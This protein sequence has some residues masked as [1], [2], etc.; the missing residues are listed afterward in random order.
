MHIS[1][2]L[3]KSSQEKHKKTFVTKRKVVPMRTL[4]GWA[5]LNVTDNLLYD[6][7]NCTE[8]IGSI[9]ESSRYFSI[10]FH[11]S[12]VHVSYDAWKTQVLEER[13]LVA[14]Q[15]IRIRSEDEFW[16][17]S[18]SACAMISIWKERKSELFQQAFELILNSVS[19]SR[20][21]GFD[22]VNSK[23]EKLRSR[24][25]LFKI[26]VDALEQKHISCLMH[27]CQTARQCSRCICKK[28]NM[29]DGMRYGPT[30]VQEVM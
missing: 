6:F 30:S 28:E 20:Q 16:K 19:D 18:S 24:A 9:P 25:L 29:N 7:C 27:G 12:L 13:T 4:C 15:P 22:S 3:K 14:F 21:P 8:K 23:A 26:A 11:K 2:C 5:V 17:M 1:T 10:C